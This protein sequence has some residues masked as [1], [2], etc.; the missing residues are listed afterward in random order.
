MSFRARG[1]HRKPRSTGR[2]IGLA[3]A[4][5]VAVI[6]LSASPAEAATTATWDRLAKC[7]SGGRW[8]INTGNGYYGGLQ[9]SP[10]TWR[11]YGGGRFAS[12][13]H[14]AT[15]AEQITVAER[16]LDARG[17]SPWPACSRKLGLDRSD[18]RGNPDGTAE[19]ASRSK[20]RKAPAKATTRKVRKVT[21]KAKPV[22][23]RRAS[24]KVHVVRR[25]DTLSGIAAR[26]D[27]PGGWQK[28]YRINKNVIGKNPGL[29]RP[30][31]RLRL[32]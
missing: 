17:W 18:A 28:L 5:L 23:V 24:G 16:L 26:R 1:R 8:H 10:G 30:G 21:K 22:A 7:E 32:R 29:I 19:R 14:R 25:G 31:Q 2:T 4:P 6:P 13:A 20:P 27:V 11:A 9:F 12:S 3:T 15:K